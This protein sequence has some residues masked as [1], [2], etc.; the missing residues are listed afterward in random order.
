LEPHFDT[1][2]RI[3]FR[4][5]WE[6]Q[7]SQEWRIL[8]GRRSR[9][10]PGVHSLPVDPEELGP[11]GRVAG[12]IRPPVRRATGT[13][14]RPPAGMS[15]NRSGPLRRLSG[16]AGARF[17]DLATGGGS[18]SAPASFTRSSFLKDSPR[19]G[20]SDCD[21]D[22]SPPVYRPARHVVCRPVRAGSCSKSRPGVLPDRPIAPGPATATGR[23]PA[24]V[25][26]ATVPQPDTWHAVPAPGVHLERHHRRRMAAGRRCP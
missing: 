6:F 22:D 3:L 14:S 12:F 18:S 16:W 9:P 21:E 20:L 11:G 19:G 2:P 10:A 15:R 24:R 4:R 5:P 25:P 23:G 13:R 1:A 26:P 17:P 7:W 8:A